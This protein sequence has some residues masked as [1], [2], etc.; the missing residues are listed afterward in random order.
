MKAEKSICEEC[1]NFDGPESCIAYSKKNP[2]CKYLLEKRSIKHLVDM[3]R[4]QFKKMAP[5]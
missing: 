5:K 4:E 1:P 3:A 2:Q